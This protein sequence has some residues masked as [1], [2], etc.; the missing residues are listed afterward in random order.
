MEII[1][2]PN[3]TATIEFPDGRKPE[4]VIPGTYRYELDYIQ[5]S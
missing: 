5:T 4:T 3:T 2:P 1:V